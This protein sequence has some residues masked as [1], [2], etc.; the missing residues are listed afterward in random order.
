[1]TALIE[2]KELM[3]KYS[4]NSFAFPFYLQEVRWQTFQTTALDLLI[5]FIDTES[6]TSFLEHNICGT[7][8]EYIDLRAL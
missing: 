8:G 5:D 1:M 6:D 4:S 7:W 2:Y 3:I